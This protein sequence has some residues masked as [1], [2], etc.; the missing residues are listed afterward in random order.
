[1]QM[2]EPGIDVLIFNREKKINT[3]PR[4]GNTVIHH[5][6]QLSWYASAGSYFLALAF[7]REGG[8]QPPAVQDVRVHDR[9]CRT[10][11]RD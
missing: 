9:K 10:R 4:C 7:L 1:M 11:A 8:M 2:K 5:I 6:R 3:R